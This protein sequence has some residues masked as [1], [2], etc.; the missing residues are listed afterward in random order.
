MFKD[1]RS[2]A[3]KEKT[4]RY[5]ATIGI[6][7]AVFCMNWSFFLFFR[8]CANFSVVFYLLGFF[9]VEKKAM[10]QPIKSVEVIDRQQ[11]QNKPKTRSLNEPEL[12]LHI[13]K[14]CSSH[15]HGCLISFIGERCDSRWRFSFKRCRVSILYLS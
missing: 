9:T 3:Q 5:F 10:I 6:C 14:V 2:P 11:D 13:P 8:L 1:Y 15:P 4:T 12:V 7:L